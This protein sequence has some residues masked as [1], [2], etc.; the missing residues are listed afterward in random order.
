[1]TDAEG[2]ASDKVRL[3]VWSDYVCPFCYLELPELQRLTSELG[4][5]MEV[6][7]RAFELRPKPQPTLDPDG[8]YLH[9]VWNASVYPMASARG[10][11]LKLP[12]VQPRSRLALEAAEHARGKDRFDSMHRAIFAAFFEHGRDIG[13]VAVLKSLAAECGIDA[14]ELEEALVQGVHTA[15]V[16]EDQALAAK[17]RI[18]GVPAS[19]VQL[20]NRGMIVPGAQPFETIRTAIE[21][22]RNA[23]QG[24]F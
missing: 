4:E 3:T 17:M 12:P 1:M 11:T 5:G 23:Q 9:R 16:L 7:W 10:M 14:D 24:S 18:S 6:D 15:K 21:Q 22:V 19:L 8:E 13:D 20:G 2:Q